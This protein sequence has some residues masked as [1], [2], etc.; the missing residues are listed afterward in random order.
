MTER[1]KTEDQDTYR[2]DGPSIIPTP[3]IECDMSLP[4]DRVVWITSLLLE[5]NPSLDA[6]ILLT[7]CLKMKTGYVDQET[8]FELMADVA[9]ELTKSIL[10][11][12]D[13]A[14]A[15]NATLIAINE[16]MTSV[17]QLLNSHVTVSGFFEK[18]QSLTNFEADSATVTTAAFQLMYLLTSRKKVRFARVKEPDPRAQSRLHPYSRK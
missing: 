14:L 10:T 6:K 11:I 4:H 2:H 5:P 17:V 15:A 1:G 12:F 18:I 9:P 13:S 16:I 7:E 3:R 8:E